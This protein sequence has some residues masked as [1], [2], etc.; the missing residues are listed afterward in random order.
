MFH[1][2]VVFKVE[3]R[4]FFC[5]FRPRPDFNCVAV[6]HLYVE[7]L[8]RLSSLAYCLQGFVRKKRLACWKQILIVFWSEI[9]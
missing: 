6:R 9:L 3:K 1:L 7:L 4:L 2:N 5:T 8:L